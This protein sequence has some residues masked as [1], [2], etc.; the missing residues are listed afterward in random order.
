MNAFRLPIVLVLGLLT[1]GTAAAQGAPGR[2]LA[3][4]CRI[5]SPSN[6]YDGT[7]SVATTAAA[8]AS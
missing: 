1:A 2:P 8:Y 4:I 3:Q 7:R 6:I 5:A